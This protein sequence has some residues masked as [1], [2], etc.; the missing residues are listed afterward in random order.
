LT[1]RRFTGW[2]SRGPPF[3]MPELGWTYGYP[4][5][6]LGMA[7]VALLLLDHFRRQSWL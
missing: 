1:P 3:A 5:T 4:A 2:T 7:P 6:M